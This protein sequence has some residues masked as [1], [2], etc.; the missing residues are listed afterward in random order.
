MSWDPK[1]IHGSQYGLGR[2]GRSVGD[3]RSN[4]HIRQETVFYHGAGSH[5]VGKIMEVGGRLFR[6]R[7]RLSDERRAEAAMSEDIVLIPL[8]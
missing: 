3:G 4:C 8:W 1:H 7:E 2:V 5:H 6:N